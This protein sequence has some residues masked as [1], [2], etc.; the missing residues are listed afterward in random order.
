MQRNRNVDLIRACACLLVLIYHGWAL[1]GS[2]FIKIPFWR[3]YVVYGGDIGVT[4][5]FVLSGYGIWHSL[6]KIEEDGKS[7][8]FKNFIKKRIVRIG[9]QYYLNLLLL[10]L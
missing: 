5:F 4:T 1:T 2:V 3:E 9:P 6:Y 10:L 8:K 7:I